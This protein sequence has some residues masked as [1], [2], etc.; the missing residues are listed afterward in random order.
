M[1][2]ELPNRSCDKSTRQDDGDDEWPI[3]AFHVV[4]AYEGV[5]TMCEGLLPRCTDSIFSQTRD[6]ESS[7]FT[8]AVILLGVLRLQL[9]LSAMKMFSWPTEKHHVLAPRPRIPLIV[10]ILRHASRVR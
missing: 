1:P 7:A 6:G 2:Q 9:R 3:M 10:A 5:V 4:T 8:R